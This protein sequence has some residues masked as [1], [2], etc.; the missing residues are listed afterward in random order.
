MALFKKFF[1]MII[2]V[3]M[4][5]ISLTVAS[6][7]NDRFSMSYLYG[8]YD[9][10][11]LVNRTNGSLNQ[12]APSWFDL[13]SDGSLHLNTV[14]TAFVSEMHTKGIKVVPFLSNHWDRTVGRAALTNM[15][16]LTD[17]LASAVIKYGLD[18]VNVDLENLNELDTSSYTA[19]VRLLRTKLGSEKTIAVAVAANP[20]G[21]T[22]GWQASYDY[23]ALAQHSDYLLIMAY[24]ES[25]E[26]GPAGP[27]A[28]IGFAEKS[29]QYALARVSKEKIVL[30]I[31][32]YGRYWQTGAAY[33]GYGASLTKIKSI[34]STYQSSVTY[35]T[36]SQSAKAT[37]TIKSTDV[38]PVI[39]SRTLG[40]GTY[41]FW[42]E[43]EASL[44]AKLA[45]INKYDIYGVGSWSLG[46]ETADTWTYYNEALN[47]ATHEITTKID[48]TVAERTTAAATTQP[49]ATTAAPTTAVTTTV[50]ST[51][52]Q[53]TTEAT[54]TAPA[55]TEPETT[56]PATTEQTA[57]STTSGKTKG[58][59]NL[60][61]KN[62]GNNRHK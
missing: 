47:G 62:T 28:S 29:I 14:N 60:K 40:A 43:N 23:A 37:V 22:R 26:S 11:A 46:Q 16:A 30:G 49:E 5:V 48:T 31:P 42:Y 19:F 39:G 1:C 57:E 54:T 36:A 2:A 21:W 6:A 53:P 45:L 3:L 25:Y 24:D 18:G 32:F 8:N 15:N 50:P 7:N 12:V 35:D 51:S 56:A 20:Y 34:I 52:A 9:Y 55:T 58:K 44:R 17:Q 61:E 10:S 4:A 59:G 27:V 41:T 13:N 38:K 33:G